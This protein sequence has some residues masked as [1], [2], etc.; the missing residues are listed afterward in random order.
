M[1]LTDGGSDSRLRD[2][3]LQS[4]SLS[5]STRTL[6]PLHPTALHGQ[7]HSVVLFELGHGKS[8]RMGLALHRQPNHPTS[9]TNALT[10]SLAA[11]PSDIFGGGP[12][13]VAWASSW[14]GRKCLKMHVCQRRWCS[15][16]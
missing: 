8:G 16:L 2:A 3:C 15:R 13:V 10:G 1:Q 9:V 12:L 6:W 11:T 4:P 7:S 14:L 5:L